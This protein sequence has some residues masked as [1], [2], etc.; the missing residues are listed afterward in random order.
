MVVVNV[1]VKITIFCRGPLFTLLGV[2]LCVFLLVRKGDVQ[3]IFQ[4]H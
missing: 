2:T 3:R 4:V 1:P